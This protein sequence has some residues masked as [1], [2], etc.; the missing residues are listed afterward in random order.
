[1][2]EIDVSAIRSEDCSILSGSQ[3]ELG[4]DAGGITWRNC[5]ALAERLPLATDTNRDDI[6]DHFREYGA[7]DSEEID[8]WSDVELSAMVWQE[9]AAGFREFEDHCDSDLEAYEKA[10]SEGRIS[11]RLHL[12]EDGKAYIYLGI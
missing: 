4:P 6:R 9:A 5:L 7:W 10:C 12:T 1:M 8:G 2:T 3:A 11:G